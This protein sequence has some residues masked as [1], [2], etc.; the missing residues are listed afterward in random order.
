[1]GTATLIRD[2][3]ARFLGHAALYRLDPPILAD[4]P[5]IIGG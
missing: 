3:L 2:H 5:Q 1:M 4:E